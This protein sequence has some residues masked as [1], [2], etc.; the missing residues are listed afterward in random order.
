MSKK[1]ICVRR[2]CGIVAIVA[3]LM[4]L[5]AAGAIE[6][7]TIA[8]EVGFRRVGVGMAVFGVC[9]RVLWG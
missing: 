9:T 1:Q 3:F 8:P 5:G 7:S 2:I 4:V 6:C